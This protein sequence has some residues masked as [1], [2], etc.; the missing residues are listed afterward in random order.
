MF[1]PNYPT[2][3][4]SPESYVLEY[5]ECS[6]KQENYLEG[7][8]GRAEECRRYVEALWGC[9]HT[10]ASSRPAPRREVLRRSAQRG[11]RVEVRAEH[12]LCRGPVR[13][14]V[15]VS[16]CL[17]PDAFLVFTLSQGA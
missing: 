1:H 16:G 17:S 13:G 5:L 9:S 11:I 6:E 14:D 8:L 10:P 4:A 2:Y 3:I 12:S 7:T 15:A